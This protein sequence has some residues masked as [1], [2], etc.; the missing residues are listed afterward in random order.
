MKT[1]CSC[2]ATHRL[3][4]RAAECR[5]KRAL[6]INGEGRY[7]LLAH[8]GNYYGRG[9]LTITLWKTR[10]EAEEVLRDLKSCGGQCIGRHEIRALPE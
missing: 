4:Q 6:W 10:E 8:C 3:Y 5:W 2:G 9:G 1:A 7:A